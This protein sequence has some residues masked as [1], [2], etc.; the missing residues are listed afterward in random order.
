MKQPVVRR[1]SSRARQSIRVLIAD[2]HHLFL[3]A[4]H[5]LLEHHRFE[6]VA[7]AADGP[8]A[9]RL[10]QDTRPDVAVLDVLMPTLGGL[11]V[12]RQ[13]I[14]VTPNTHV[15]LVT[16]SSDLGF[17]L[18][19]MALGVRGFV[20][21]TGVASEL[22]DA[23]RAAA[24]G[25]TYVSPAYELAMGCGLPRSQA[26]RVASLTPR[27]RQVL[28]LIAE[29]KTTRQIAASLGIALKTAE[30]HRAR[31][32]R[33]LDIHG[34]AGLVRYAI[35]T[36]FTENDVKSHHVQKMPRSSVG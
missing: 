28:H 12:A 2:D 36:G 10:A 32:M 35:G 13:L 29:G 18:E 20:V 9:V 17:V 8:D 6:V 23:I 4:I 21:K 31:L 11:D 26:T 1:Q 27:E 33:K 15:V 34:I 7:V 14:G 16:G 25:A 5:R 30:T 19:G 3:E 22:F 24:R